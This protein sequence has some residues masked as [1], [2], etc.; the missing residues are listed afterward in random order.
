LEELIVA[1]V[2]IMPS[3]N[4]LRAGFR[5]FSVAEYHRLIELGILTEDDNLEL[6]DGYLVHKMARNPPHDSTLSRLSRILNRHILDEWQVRVQ[7]GVTLSHSEPEP[8]IAVVRGDDHA[9]DRRHPG[10]ADFGI[11]VE[12]SDSTLDG[13]RVD[14][15]RIYAQS[16]IPEYWIV[17]LVDRQIEV[18]SSP[19]GPTAMPAFNVQHVYRPGHTVPFA[20]DGQHIADIAVDDLLP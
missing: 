16:N 6:L 10:P 15:F 1:A 20:L 2:G 8:D 14:K 19:S 11:I 12:V 7:M 5:R 17:N 13:D 9:F 4:W 3:T 18:Y